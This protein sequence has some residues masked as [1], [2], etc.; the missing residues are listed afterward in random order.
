MHR[1]G[2]SVWTYVKHFIV[3]MK[4]ELKL[5]VCLYISTN[6]SAILDLVSFWYIKLHH[7]M[8]LINCCEKCTN[9]FVCDFLLNDSLSN[10]KYTV[11]P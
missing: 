5:H 4:F 6:I 8:A 2:P 3:N 1:I 9:N 10:S 7:K 11:L